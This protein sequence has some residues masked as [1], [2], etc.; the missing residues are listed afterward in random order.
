MRS[1]ACSTRSGGTQGTFQVKEMRDCRLSKKAQKENRLKL[2]DALDMKQAKMCT[3][4]N[5]LWR[6]IREKID[7]ELGVDK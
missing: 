3:K 7:A 2:I 1:V 5:R 6:T 4:L